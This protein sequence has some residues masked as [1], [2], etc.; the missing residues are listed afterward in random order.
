MGRRLD[1]MSTPCSKVTPGADTDGWLNF[2]V[3]SVRGGQPR[4]QTRHRFTVDDRRYSKLNNLTAG[5]L[6]FVVLAAPIPVASNR[7]LL[8]MLWAAAIGILATIYLVRGLL[9]DPKRALRSRQHGV[10]FGLASLVPA[11]ALVQ[12][13]PIAAH[14]PDFLTS[15]PVTGASA[16]ASISL[17]PSGT[18]VGAV[19]MASYIIFFALMLE[20]SGRRDRAAFVAWVLFAGV[21]AHALWALVSLNML[22]DQFFWGDKQFY[23][24]SA[25]GTFVNRNSFATFLAMGLVLGIALVVGRADRRQRRAAAKPGLLSAETMEAVL[26]WLLVGLIVI[27]LLATQSRMGMIAGGIGAFVCLAIMIWKSGHK[28]I[29]T[30][31]GVLIVGCAGFFALLMLFG[32]ALI[33]RLIFA[34]VDSLTRGE[35]YR[36]VVGMVGERPLV[37]FGLDSFPVAFELFHQLPLSSDSVWDYAHSTYLALWAELGIIIGSIPLVL[38]LLLGARLIQV[39]RRRQSD[40]PLAVA[41]LAALLVAAIHSLVDFSLE[42]QANVFFLLALMALGIARGRSVGPGAGKG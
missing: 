39:I 17:M 3:H 25:T 8:W 21:V 36:Q 23:R 5:S 28:R 26:L 22:G 14:L 40:Y 38:G 13:L 19:R 16:P 2:D 29:G 30:L 42:I 18:A 10:L 27:T 15:L 11:F 20:V 1:G 35:L 9:I 7:P 41:A 12:M 24:G 37:G 31:I 33:E 32:R 4:E 6:V 34:G